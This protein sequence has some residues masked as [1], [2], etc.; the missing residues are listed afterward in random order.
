MSAKMAA[1]KRCT[2]PRNPT[3]RG[4][5]GVQAVSNPWSE[6]IAAHPVNE[7]LTQI[8]SL[9][10]QATGDTAI[11]EDETLYLRRAQT[12]SDNFKL[13]LAKSDAALIP[14]HILNK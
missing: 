4:S 1:A 6:R 14:V 10:K 9:L 2:P 8:E 5:R 11:G 7:R 3:Y 13:R 12:I